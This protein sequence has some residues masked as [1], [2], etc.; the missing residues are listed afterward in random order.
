MR[1]MKSASSLRI[2]RARAIS[3]DETLQRIAEG[4]VRRKEGLILLPGTC[5]LPKLKILEH[6]RRAGGGIKETD[7][8]M[9]GGGDERSGEGQGTQHSG[10]I[11]NKKLGPGEPRPTACQCRPEDG[12]FA[13]VRREVGGSLVLSSWEVTA[14]VLTRLARARCHLAAKKTVPSAPSSSLPLSSALFHPPPPPPF[15][16]PPLSPSLPS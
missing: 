14:D 5:H 3:S 11:R 8:A 10:K 16:G 4:G 1:S 12:P 7:V 13:L 9:K 6:A 2:C 15:A